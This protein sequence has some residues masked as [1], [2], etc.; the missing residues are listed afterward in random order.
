MTV[1]AVVIRVAEDVYCSLAFARL[2]A[3]RADVTGQIDVVAVV[4]RVALLVLAVQSVQVA[5]MSQL[6]ILLVSR[7]ASA[8]AIHA[9]LIV[10]AVVVV[11]ARFAVVLQAHVLHEANFGA[12]QMSCALFV[13]FARF[14][15][16]L[17]LETVVLFLVKERMRLEKKLK[18]IKKFERVRIKFK[19]KEYFASTSSAQAVQ[20][21]H[22]VRVS[23]AKTS[24]SHQTR[25]TDRLG[26]DVTGEAFLAVVVD[27][28]ILF[29]AYSVSIGHRCCCQNR[30]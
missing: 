8:F 6:I 24:K 15:K 19:K 4:V 21:V 14:A 2:G 23:R 9:Q 22:A 30:K 13:L 7:V 29:E 12:N 5:V 11:R 27:S 28:T 18:T 17:L 3:R 1:G 26:S 10:G 16:R 25:E 20:I